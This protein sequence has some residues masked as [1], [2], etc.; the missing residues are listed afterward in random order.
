MHI[1][2]LLQAIGYKIKFVDNSEQKEDVIPT[3]GGD[4][5]RIVV[6]CTNSGLR[7]CLEN[8]STCSCPSNASFWEVTGN[9]SQVKTN[10][11][12]HVCVHAHKSVC[13]SIQVFVIT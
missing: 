4:G 10:I 2:S 5:I 7:A 11:C 8:P 9:T 6:T 13:M 3:A 12:I 1:I